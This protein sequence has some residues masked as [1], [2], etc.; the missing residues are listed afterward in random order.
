MTIGMALAACGGLVLGFLGRS[1]AGS[2]QLLQEH[3]YLIVGMA[4]VPPVVMF[5]EKWAHPEAWRRLKQHSER[6][7]LRDMLTFRHIPD[8][9]MKAEA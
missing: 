2:M 7:T 8:L 1:H 9:R 6:A 3:P 5:S 4:A